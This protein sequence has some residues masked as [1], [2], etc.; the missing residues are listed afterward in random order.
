MRAKPAPSEKA[1]APCRR[2]L[3]H[4]GRVRWRRGRGARGSEWMDG[5]AH[6]LE[7]PPVAGTFQGLR[8]AD[9]VPAQG[10]VHRLTRGRQRC[11]LSGPGSRMACT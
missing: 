5:W 1:P 2:M 6:V 7:G 11:T 10:R 3:A 8:H 9:A 4:P